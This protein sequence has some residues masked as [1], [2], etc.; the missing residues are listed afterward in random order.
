MCDNN[1]LILLQFISFMTVSGNSVFKSKPNQLAYNFHIQ[2]K[3]KLSKFECF[4]GCGASF[5]T[6][7]VSVPKPLCT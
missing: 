3:I 2:N 7:V 5:C 1:I 4:A 6:N